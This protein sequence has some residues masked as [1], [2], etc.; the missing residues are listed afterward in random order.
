MYN[1]NMMDNR[2]ISYKEQQGV[3]KGQ[4]ITIHDSANEIYLSANLIS[5]DII[6][7]H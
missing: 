7:D 4:G 2:C 1:L 6:Q 5:E 3:D